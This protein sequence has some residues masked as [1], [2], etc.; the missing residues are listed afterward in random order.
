MLS[1]AALQLFPASLL[2]FIATAPTVTQALDN[3]WAFRLRPSLW[4]KSGKESLPRRDETT[5]THH[6]NQVPIAVRKMTGDQ[7]EMFFPEYWQFEA[8]TNGAPKL[9]QDRGKPTP[10]SLSPLEDVS[11][12]KDWPNAS[13]PHPLQAPFSLHTN[14]QLDTRPLISRLLR[15][16]GAIFALDTRDYACPGGTDACTAINRPNSCCTAGLICQLTTNVGLGDVGCCEPGQ[17]CGQEVSGCPEEYT[18]CPN[19]LGGGCCIPGSACN[20][21]GCKLTIRSPRCPMILI[22]NLQ[23]RR[24]HYSDLNDRA[25]G[26]RVSHKLFYVLYFQ[27]LNLTGCHPRCPFNVYVHL[28]G[29]N[30]D[31]LNRDR[32]SLSF[33]LYIHNPVNEPARWSNPS[34]FVRRS[35]YNDNS[36]PCDSHAFSMSDRL[37][38]M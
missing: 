14:V 31:H 8:G 6:M 36:L 37:F 9:D 33:I 11:T 12:V 30:L 20:G 35:Y 23:R 7:G 38:S 16:P 3:G 25:Y 2:L 29:Y 13:M 10:R 5:I 24:W 22:F 18:L 27:L 32:F 19:S 34:N 1:L 21:V 4:S 17:A 15:S 26:N 28:Y